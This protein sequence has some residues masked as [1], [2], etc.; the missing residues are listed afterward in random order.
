M[1]KQKKNNLRTND[2]PDFFPYFMIMTKIWRLGTLKVSDGHNGPLG[3]ENNNKKE[4]DRGEK[5]P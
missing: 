4:K 2:F 1:I 5:W 3:G